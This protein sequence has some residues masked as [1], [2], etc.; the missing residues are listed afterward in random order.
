[1][2]TS[3]LLEETGVYPAEK[4]LILLLASLRPRLQTQSSFAKKVLG[5][6]TPPLL[7]LEK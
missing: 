5:T 7:K 2:I 3:N 4:S 6:H 1:M